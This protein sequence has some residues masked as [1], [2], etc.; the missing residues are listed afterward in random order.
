MI[1]NTIFNPNFSNIN[2]VQYQRGLQMTEMKSE[3]HATLAVHIEDLHHASNGDPINLSRYIG[4]YFSSKNPSN[5]T[6]TFFPP[7]LC[8][9]VMSDVDHA[10]WEEFE[11]YAIFDLKSTYC[12]DTSSFTLGAD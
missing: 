9:E 4:L 6:E 1:A 7:K 8:T 12:P 11:R 2:Y 3:G 5:L 10:F